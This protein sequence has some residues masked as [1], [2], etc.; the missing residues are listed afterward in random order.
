MRKN[1]DLLIT[2]FGGWLGVHCFYKGNYKKG[3]LYLF[4]FG[5]F[6]VGWAYDVYK[7]YKAIKVREA[8][9][10]Q[11]QK[12]I[13]EIEEIINNT[14]TLKYN[15]SERNITYDVINGK[16]IVKDYIVLDFETTGLHSSHD[17]I[18][19]FTFLKY[20]NNVLVD[21]YSSLVNPECHIPTKITDLTGITNDMV[22][23]EKTIKDD[24]INI[25]K[26]ID[27]FTLIGHNICSFDFNFLK[28]AIEDNA[29]LNNNIEFNCVDTLI[30]AQ[31]LLPELENHKLVTLKDY[32]N[33]ECASHRSKEDCEV[34]A[35][36]YK[37]LTK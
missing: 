31:E 27:G 13:S 34:T 23:N 10:N 20:I 29:K 4:T 28:Q 32:L 12:R 17:K 11:K 15:V 24:I 36:L 6:C 1:K 8:Y 2:I 30:M 16:K 5:G 7:E 21:E 14:V 9:Y 37:Y 25:L 22:K 18:I 35:E 3:I 33:I 26:F 19:E